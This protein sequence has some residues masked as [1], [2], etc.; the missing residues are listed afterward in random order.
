MRVLGHIHTFND[1]E[2][3]GR[4]IDALLAQTYR[5]QEVLIVDNGS[6]DDTLTQLAGK[7]VTVIEHSS[8]QG[9]SGAVATG[10]RYAAAQ[11]CDWIWILDADSSPRPDAL[12]QLVSLYHTFPATLQADLWR[13]SSLL[14]E[15]PTWNNTI[16]FSL[17]RLATVRHAPQAA[18]RD[19]VVFNHK[20]YRI[21]RPEPSH[22]WYECDATIWSGSLYK[23]SAV[24]KIGLPEVDYVLDWGEYAYGYRG[25]QHGYR[26]FVHKGSIV[27]HN[28]TGESTLNIR[29]YRLGWFAFNMIE[30][31][32]IRCYYLV[33]NILYFW[34]YQYEYRNFYTLVPRLYKVLILTLNFLLR[35]HSHS[36]QLVACL[37]GISD[38]LLKQMHRRY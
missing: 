26:G 32:A 20:G 3:I 14:M 16:P 8:N 22:V 36:P 37:R 12:A 13:L 19:G 21:V 17:L 5:L 11:Q 7:H 33:R 30:L 2:S 24:A 27:D 9:T 35:A 4:C 1:A 23:L 28:V 34:L 6:S 31:P 25:K 15:V 10:M 38:G 18:P 29:R